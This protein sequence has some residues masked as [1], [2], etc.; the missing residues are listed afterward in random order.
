MSGASLGSDAPTTGGTP[1]PPQAI[2]RGFARRGAWPYNPSL[3]MAG[4]GERYLEPYVRAAARHGEG[5]GSLLWASPQTQGARFDA[6]MRLCE[7]GGRNVL[8]VGCG[9]ADFLDHLIKREVRPAH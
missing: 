4:K 3:T 8:D 9:R 5:F 7:F 1:V 2:S 6:L